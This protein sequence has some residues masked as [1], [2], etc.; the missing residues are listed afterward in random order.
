MTESSPDENDVEGLRCFACGGP[1]HPATGHLWRELSA[2]AYC[3]PC[4]RSFLSWL[5]PHMHRRWSGERFYEAAARRQVAPMKIAIGPARDFPSWH[6][7]G[8]DLVPAL[9]LSHDVRVFKRY[10]ELDDESFDA[11]VIVKEPPSSCCAAGSRR[12]VYL[13]VDFFE[14]EDQ[15]EKHL[16]FLRSCAVV[17][18]HCSR[19]DRHLLPHCRRLAHVEHYGK[20]VLPEI[21]S[22]KPDG[23]VLWTGQG[24]WVKHTIKWHDR[25][26]RDFDLVMLAN[27]RGWSWNSFPRPGISLAL[28]SEREHLRLLG[29]ARAGLD[30]KGENFHQ[31]TKPPTK[32]QQFV[33]SGVP[34]A[35]NRDSYSWE[36]FHERGFDLADPDDEARWFSRRY[37]EETREFGLH[38]RKEISKESVVASYLDLLRDLPP[39]VI[40]RRTR[41]YCASSRMPGAMTSSGR[42]P[43]WS[44]SRWRADPACALSS[45]TSPW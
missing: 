35:V 41:C 19:L 28:W 26:K 22:Y 24:M 8:G 9:R 43:G 30:V 23:F 38:L 4:Y 42:L 13:P 33:A 10:R 32:I 21:S 12:I 37:W 45:G 34:A 40:E 20:Q 39:D 31:A 6:W 14:S 2:V 18:T 17:A 1:Y 16:P 29:K 27:D 15:I 7:C 3:G 44:R 11:V 25:R 5:K 36:W